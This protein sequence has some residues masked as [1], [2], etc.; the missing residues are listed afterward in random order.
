MRQAKKKKKEKEGKKG[1]RK[2]FLENQTIAMTPLS[3]GF[4]IKKIF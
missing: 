2:I 3:S 4:V 1:K